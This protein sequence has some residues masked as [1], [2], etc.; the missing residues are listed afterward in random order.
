MEESKE[1]NDIKKNSENPKFPTNNDNNQEKVNFSPKE[2]PDK[3]DDEANKGPVKRVPKLKTEMK[4]RSNIS[5]T[6]ALNILKVEKKQV[7]LAPSY[8]L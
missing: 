8:S 1:S 7:S 2:I 4:L 6:H 3:K 5:Y